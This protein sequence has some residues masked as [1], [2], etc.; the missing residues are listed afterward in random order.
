[1][2]EVTCPDC[3]HHNQRSARF[4][5]SCGTELASGEVTTS[6]AVVDADDGGQ[7]AEIDR[8]SFGVDQGLFVVLEGSKAGARY[9]L[10]SDLVRVGRHPDSDIFLDDIT[11]SRRHAEVHRSG[12]SY[13]VVDVGSLNGTYLNRERVD[14]AELS[15]GD[16]VRIGKYKLVFTH[17]TGP[18]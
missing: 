15:D 9:S 18:L 11:V 5:S 13:R 6:H 17:G 2:D 14:D 16:E 7:L 3:G 8:S 1:M 10:D 4:C 12:I